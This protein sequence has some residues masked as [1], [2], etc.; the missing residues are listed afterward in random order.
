[1]NVKSS[2][3][4]LNSGYVHAPFTD[5]DKN[6]YYVKKSNRAERGFTVYRLNESGDSGRYLND[7]DL[8]QIEGVSNSRWR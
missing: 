6:K 5:E 2:E 7:N 1:M 8:K 3:D 4:L